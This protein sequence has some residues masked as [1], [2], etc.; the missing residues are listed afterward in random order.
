MA[1]AVQVGQQQ[2]CPEVL[3]LVHSTHMRAVEVVEEIEKEQRE[4]AMFTVMYGCFQQR[5][6]SGGLS[7][8]EDIEF[9]SWEV[10]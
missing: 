8:S 6:V 1:V 7:R 5:S 2:N 9:N 10:S 4:T 3:L